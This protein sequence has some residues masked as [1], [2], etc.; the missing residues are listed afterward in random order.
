MRGELVKDLACFR[1]RL[2]DARLGGVASKALGYRAHDGAVPHL[3]VPRDFGA[4]HELG[5]RAVMRELA[6]KLGERVDGELLQMRDAAE[7]GAELRGPAGALFLGARRTA[8][9]ASARFRIERLRFDLAD[10]AR[11]VGH[12]DVATT[13]GYVQSEGSRPLRVSQRALELLDP[14]GSRPD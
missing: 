2:D 1:C 14:T 11:F 9:D 3:V 4:R 8:P 5:R 6:T 13:R 7:V 10:V 12:S